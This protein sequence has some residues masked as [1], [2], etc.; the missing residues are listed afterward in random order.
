MTHRTPPLPSFL[1][2]GAQKGGTRWLRSN[3]GKHPEIFTAGSELMFFNTSEY[4]LGLDHYRE[5]FAGWDGEPALG[6]ATPGYM[7]WRHDPAA[8]ARRIDRDLPGVQLFAVLRDPVDRLYSAFIHHVR[9]GRLDPDQ[10]IVE[11]VRSASPEE[12]R[13]QLV[14]GGWYARSLAPYVDLFGERLTVILNEDTRDRPEKIYAEGL[15]RLG[16]DDAFVPEG[17]ADV[18]FSRQ[19]PPGTR[20]ATPEGGRRPLSAE[21]KRGLGEYYADDVERL[22]AMLGRDLSAWKH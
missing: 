14:A 15:R 21:E 6:E 5:S 3:L 10:D 17:L 19:P 9:R 22:E 7:I 1:I 12:D 2:I 16:V 20:Y 8:V 11:L 13:K 4:E 18:V